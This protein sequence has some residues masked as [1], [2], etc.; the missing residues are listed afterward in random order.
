M[1]ARAIMKSVRVVPRKTRL[2]ADLI[3]GKKIGEANAILK[4]TPNIATE[5]LAK[6]LKSAVANAEHNYK[7][8]VAKLYIKEIFVNEGATL[9]RMQPRA[10]GSGAR[11]LKR[12]SHITVVVA[13]LN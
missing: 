10:K 4:A 7:M 3:R 13:E 8:D 2:V 1:E 9:K 11:I 5:P 6:V 12:S